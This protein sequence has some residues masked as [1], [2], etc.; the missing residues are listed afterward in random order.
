VQVTGADN[1]CKG[2]KNISNILYWVK[3]WS[4]DAL[5][6]LENHLQSQNCDKELASHI[7]DLLASRYVD[8]SH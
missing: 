3:D 6:A 5:T 7:T 8:L 1:E 4:E 2:R